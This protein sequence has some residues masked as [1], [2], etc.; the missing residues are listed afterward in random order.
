VSHRELL[1]LHRHADIFVFPTLSE[2]FGLAVAEAMASGLPI[3]TTPTG[4]ALDYLHHLDSA[5][6]V[7]PREPGAIAT[8]VERLLGDTSLREKL[9]RAAQ[10]AAERLRPEKSWREYGLH[11]ERLTQ[12]PST[13]Q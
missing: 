9:G 11:L 4:A 6:F 1:H 3:V 5:L 8:S 13:R 12:L 10:Q 2:G 7:P